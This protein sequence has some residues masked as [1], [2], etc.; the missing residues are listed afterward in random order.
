M[1]SGS[2]VRIAGLEDLDALV[3]L[4]LDAREEGGLPS[5]PGARGRVARPTRAVITDP[6]LK[7]LMAFE[8]GQP[9]GFALLRPLAPSV[10]YD[11]PRLQ[12]E[13]L[14]VAEGFRRRGHGRGLLRAALECAERI[15]APDITVLSVGG[16]RSVQRFLA[17]LGFVAA[18][19]QR[20][21]DTPTL[22]AALDAETGRR[23]TR[24]VDQIIA[25]RK[26]W[27]GEPAAIPEG[28]PRPVAP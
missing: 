2:P 24:K 8:D 16:S 18:A 27:R 6:A 28:A 12:I 13:G 1:V 4:A 23:G 21:I 22:A 19:S 26:R 7:P 17:R 9:V 5:P 14:F 11:L 15:G 20:V 25:R 3:A 10:M